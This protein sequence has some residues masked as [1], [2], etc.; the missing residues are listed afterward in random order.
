MFSYCAINY[1]FCCVK[2]LVVISRLGFL[3]AKGGLVIIGGFLY[4]GFM[5][6]TIRRSLLMLCRTYSPLGS[7]RTYSPAVT[8]CPNSSTYV[9]ATT[10]W[11]SLLFYS[12]YKLVRCV[13]IPLSFRYFLFRLD[14]F[15]SRLLLHF[16]FGVFV[17]V[18]LVCTFWCWK[19]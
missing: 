4:G 1:Y 18:R 12:L 2:P 8:T 3:S 13:I 15:V 5:W 14:A 19:L 9:V 6:L 11:L 16:L 17:I 7:S 10:D